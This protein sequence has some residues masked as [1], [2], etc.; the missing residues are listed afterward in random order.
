MIKLSVPGEAPLQALLVEAVKDNILP[1][2]GRCNLSCLFCSHLQNPPGVKVYE[3]PHLPLELITDLWGGIDPGRKIIIGES[4]T[5]LREG[6][7]F[8]HPRIMELLRRL[9]HT[10]PETPVQI[11]TNGTL[12][13]TDIAVA[14]GELHPLELIISLNSAGPETRSRIMKDRQPGRALEGVELCSRYNIPYHGSV[15]AMPHLSG[16]DDLRKTLLFLDEYEARTIRLF[17]PGFT[18]FAPRKLTFSL[19]MVEKIRGFAHDMQDELNCPLLVEPPATDRLA[20]VLAGVISGTPGAGAG[21]RRGDE[22]LSVNGIRPRT[23]VE[24]FRDIFRYSDPVIEIRRD[25]HPML[26]PLEG[27]PKGASSGVVMLHDL[28]P[29]DTVTLS[30]YLQQGRE[31]LVMT[32]EGAYP[33]WQQVAGAFSLP[34]FEV[35]AVPARFFGGTICCA[36]LLT[37]DDFAR[38]LA[39]ITPASRPEIILLPPVSFD[40]RGMDITGKAQPVK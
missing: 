29:A 10:F 18:R 21:L 35:M 32:S 40:H 20:P 2:T 28:D 3:L 9:R 27:K 24:A 37:A 11:T 8:T 19:E 14:L 6:E 16:W 36:G 17:V 13:T 22:I 31:V 26:C 39:T 12:L 34:P 5:R 38:Q 4:V 7:P 33:V 23:R 25:G 15:V 1:V 30:R